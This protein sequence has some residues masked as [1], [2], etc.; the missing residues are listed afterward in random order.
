MFSRNHCLKAL[1]L[2]LNSKLVDTTQ[3]LYEHNQ[4]F[5]T[6][7]QWIL[8][9]NI[10]TSLPPCHSHCGLLGR[11]AGDCMEE[12]RKGSGR[13]RKWREDYGCPV[14]LITV[15]LLKCWVTVFVLQWML[16]R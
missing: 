11:V 9:N 5:I 10:H 14:T 7:G 1:S 3:K 16:L 6:K 12:E 8:L 13:N 4:I 2:T 15:L